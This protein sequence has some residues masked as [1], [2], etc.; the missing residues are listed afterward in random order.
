[1]DSARSERFDAAWKMVA[2]EYQQDMVFPEN[3]QPFPA[4]RASV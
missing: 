1:M 3:V 2:A 4:R